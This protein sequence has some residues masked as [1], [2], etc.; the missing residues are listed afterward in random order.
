MH[1][2]LTISI[3]EEIYEAL[4]LN[5]GKRQISKFIEEL[6]P[7]RRCEIRIDQIDPLNGHQLKRFFLKVVYT[8]D[9]IWFER[10]A[11]LAFQTL[12]TFC[13]SSDNA[14][15]AGKHQD[16]LVGFRQI[17]RAQNQAFSFDERH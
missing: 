9:R 3:D 4:Y 7:A 16:D 14:V 10:T 6:R 13:H 5:V 1:K 15:I 2:K 12:R 17:V 11:E 8:Y